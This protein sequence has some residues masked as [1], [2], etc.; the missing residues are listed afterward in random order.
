[1]AKCSSE[2]AIALLV[3]AKSSSYRQSN[4]A[5]TVERKMTVVRTRELRSLEIWE[6]LDNKS[7]MDDISVGEIE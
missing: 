4:I 7:E 1:V 2:G 6:N 5:R 3:Y